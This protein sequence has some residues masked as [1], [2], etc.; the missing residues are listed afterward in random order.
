MDLL[1]DLGCIASIHHESESSRW[2]PFHTV[3]VGHTVA[4]PSCVWRFCKRPQFVCYLFSI[5]QDY[6]VALS[7]VIRFAFGSF[8]A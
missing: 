5:Q 6:S 8:S 3:L 1:N 2:M 7:H 4:L